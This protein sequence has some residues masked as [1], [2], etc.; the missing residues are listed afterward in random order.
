MVDQKIGAHFGLLVHAKL[1][2]TD[3]DCEDK[4][5]SSGHNNLFSC[6]DDEGEEMD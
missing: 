2:Q 1:I 3:K 6:K 4:E 5:P